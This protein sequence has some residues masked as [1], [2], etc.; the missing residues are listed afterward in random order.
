MDDRQSVKIDTSS[1]IRV[2]RLLWHTLHVS[3][4][5]KSPE[6]AGCCDEMSSEVASELVSALTTSVDSQ[7]A[8][9][10]AAATL[11]TIA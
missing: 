1:P 4:G 10:A 3:A 6:V 2:A 5:S 7:S 8:T 11:P 9:L